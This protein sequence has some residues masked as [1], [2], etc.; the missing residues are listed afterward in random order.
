MNFNIA[1]Y[2]NFSLYTDTLKISESKLSKTGES[3]FFDV[4]LDH[5][6]MK[7][8]KSYESPFSD[9]TFA[10]PQNSGNAFV[11][12]YLNYSS[13]KRVT[14]SDEARMIIGEK[15]MLLNQLLETKRT[16]IAAGK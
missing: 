4:F 2:F 11:D 7:Y 3:S 15:R 1:D 12:S 10:Y 8:T 6:P 5:L 9:F 16:E 13:D 14:F